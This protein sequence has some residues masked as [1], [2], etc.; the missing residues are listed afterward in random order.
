MDSYITIESKEIIIP[1]AETVTS[2]NISLST[3]VLSTVVNN[4]DIEI[5]LE[6]NNAV[7]TSDLY[8]D[9]TFKIEFPEYV[10][11]VTVKN[12]NILYSEGLNIK[13]ITKQIENG[14][15]V[16][17]VTLEGI[18]SQFS[19][20][21]VTNGTNIILGT[22]IKTKLLTPSSDNVIKL[23]YQN[24]N[25]VSYE[26]IDEST[27]MGYN[28]TPVSFV[29]PTGMLAVNKISDYEETGKSIISVN[30]G[31]VV[32]KIEMDSEA[33]EAKMDL[34]LINNTG[35][36]CNSLRVL[37]RIPFEGNKKVGTDEDLQTTVNTNMI[38]GLS[39]DEK[40][41]QNAK[42]YY[43]ENGEA[44]DDLSLIHI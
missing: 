10:E 17:Y 27:G 36:V 26:Q 3:N 31:T 40:Y 7:E 13:E 35:S 43:S 8:I 29:S 37:G 16:L 19:T 38:Q 1:L 5:K 9:G 15:I 24:K 41:A 44:T 28:E 14:K 23:Y 6:L 33:I 32:D 39:I 25:A 11:D 30:Q 20:G 22:D 12:S 2:A 21:T 42:I 18:Q 4:E 34:M